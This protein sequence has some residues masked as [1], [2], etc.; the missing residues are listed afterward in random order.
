MKLVLSVIL[1]FMVSMPACLFGQAG[2]KDPA[3]Y[4]PGSVPVICCAGTTCRNSNYTYSTQ[5]YSPPYDWVISG[6]AGVDYTKTSGGGPT[7]HSISITW[8]TLGPQSVSVSYN[9]ATGYGTLP[10]TVEETFP[11]SVI[12]TPSANPV[13]A[14]TP[15]TFTITTTN[16]GTSPTYKWFRN[17][18]EVPG[19][20]NSTYTFI[21]ANNDNVYCEVTSSLQCPTGSPAS[22]PPV[23]IIV[24]SNFPVSVAV[25][26]S[27]NPVCQGS[28]VTFTAL[29][30][31]GGNTPSYQW[32]LGV[33][34]ISGATDSTYV[35]TPADGDLISC[36][37]TSS[38][39]CTSGNP[40]TSSQL[41]MTVS[42]VQ[43]VSVTVLPSANPVCA[44]NLV[45]YTATPV[46]GGTLP[47][48]TWTV[49]GTTIGLNGPTMQYMPVNGDAV[50]CTLNSNAQCQ[51]GN[52]ASSAAIM[53]NVQQFAPVSVSIVAS[54]STTLCNGAAVTLTATAINQGPGPVY[55]WYINN[56]HVSAASGSTY[57]YTPTNGDIVK[58]IVTS[59]L[60]CGT[61]NP[62]TSNEIF[63]T[64]SSVTTPSVTVAVSSNPVCAGVPVT[65]TATPAN[66]G[67]SPSYQWIKNGAN[68]FGA[69]TSVYIYTPANNDIVKCMMVSNSMCTSGATVFS[70]PVTM[71]VISVMAVSVTIQ[72]SENPVCQGGPVTFT[73]YPQPV[74]GTYSY[75]WMV[76]GAPSGGATNNTF[77][78][79]PV[80]GQVVT[81]VVTSPL[82]CVT[83]NPATSNAITMNVANSIPVSA[84]ITAS[85]NPSCLGSSVIF[86]V[87]PTNGGATPAFTWLVDGFPM[88]GA[89]NSTYSFVPSNGNT[90]ACTVISSYGCASGNPASSN[91]ITMAVNPTTPV[92]VV[93]TN[94]NDSSCLGVPM[95]YSAAVTGGGASP[96]Y[97]WTVN[98]TNSGINS[99]NF[100][101]IPAQGDIVKC[102]VTPD[103]AC[104]QSNPAV[105]N[106]ITQTVLPIV[107][108]DIVI[109]ASSNPVC[110]GTQV[111]Y[112]ISFISN[113]GTNPGYQWKKNG[114]LVSVSPVLVYTPANNDKISCALTSSL[115]CVNGNPKTSNEITMLVSDSLNV[116]ATIF[117]T[118][119]NPNPF[120]QGLPISFNSTV[121]NGG[122]P[123]T[124]PGYQ[125]LVNG[126]PPV[127]AATNATY[128]YIPADGDFVTLQVTSGLSCGVPKPFTSNPISLVKNNGLPAS[129]IITA[130]ENP[131][132]SGSN[133]TFHATP[134][135][136]G[137]APFYR[138]YVNGVQKSAGLS[139]NFSWSITDGMVIT[140]TVQSNLPCASGSPATSNAIIMGTVA[141]PVP[142]I[143]IST[144]TNPF[145][146]GTNVTFNSVITN[147]GST[148]GYQWN[149]N[150]NPISG[151]TNATYVTAT[152]LANN[153]II[154]CTMTSAASCIVGV[155]ATSNAITM[156]STSPLPLEILVTAS[157]NPVC[158][159]TTV[160]YTA[161]PANAG[162]SP[163]FQWQKNAF[164]IT[165][166]T[167]STY[168]HVPVNSDVIACKVTTSMVCAT[169]IDKTS[170]PLTMTVNT[171]LAVSFSI[172]ASANPVCLGTPVTLTASNIVNAGS[173]PVFKWRVD[174]VIL[175]TSGSTTFTYTPQNGDVV[176]A[177]MSSSLDCVSSNPAVSNVVVLQVNSPLPVSL[178]VAASDNPFCAG[179]GVTFVA[180]ASNGGTAPTYQWY[181]NT[182]LQPGE[183][184]PVYS[185]FPL[186][187]DEVYCTVNSNQSCISNNPAQS[188]T[189]HM[190]ATAAGMPATI[191]VTVNK[192]NVCPG[193]QL[194][195]SASITN[196]GS[197][198]VYQWYKNNN[199]VGTNVSTYATTCNNNDQVYCKITSNLACANPVV[200]NSNVIIM[201]VL[202]AAPVSIVITASSN[203][204][205]EGTAVTYTAAAV[206]PGTDP[207][208]RWKVN[209]IIILSSGSTS[210]TYTPIN[211]QVI[212]CQIQ[213]N[214]LCANPNVVNSNNII[215]SV[216][217]KAVVGVSILPSA[218]PICEGTSITY[219]ATPVNGGTL[220]AYQWKLNGAAAGTNSPTFSFTPV[221]NDKVICVITSNSDCVV[222]NTVSSVEDTMWVSPLLPV[223]ASIAASSNPVCQGYVTLSATATNGGILPL[224]QWKVN[225]IPGSLTPNNTLIYLPADGDQVTCDVTSNQFCVVGNP[226]T[227]NTVTL[228]VIPS[229]PVS[230]SIAPAVTPLPLCQGSSITFTATA[231][232]GGANPD[233]QWMLGNYTVGSGPSYTYIPASGDVITCQ[234]YSNITCPTGNP[235]TSAPIT[236]NFSPVLEPSVSITTSANPTCTG[237]M[238]SFTALPVN[239]GATPEFQWLVN[240]IPPVPAAT[241]A[242]YSYL[243]ANADV[244]T[245]VLTSGVTCP[246]INP[247][248]SNSITMS[249][250]QPQTAS[251]SISTPATS[252][253]DGI[254]VTFTA[255]LGNPGSTPVLQWFVNGTPTGATSTTYT[256]NPVNGDIVTCTLV[257][258]ISCITNNPV[259][260]NALQMTVSN[261]F[262]VSITIAPTANP[263]CV[264]QL[265][266]FTANPVN[267]GVNPVF[268]WM[269][270]G[271]NVGNNSPTYTFMPASGQVVCCQLKSDYIC[272]PD[273]AMSNC[274]TMVVKTIQ[275]VD[276]TL[277]CS[278]NPTCLGS[279]VTYTATPSNGGPNP[280]YTW[281]VNGIV[282]AGE[283][284]STYTYP[285]SSGDIVKCKL[286]SDES[287][288]NANPAMSEEITM[289]VS[290]SFP[291]DV[292]VTSTGNVVCVFTPVTFTAT[293]FFGGP[294]P[295]YQWQVNGTDVIGATNTTYLYYPPVDGNII[296]CVMTS[297]LSL[298]TANPVTSVP[299]VMIV[300]Q[301]PVSVVIAV[302][303]QTPVCEG[304]LVTFTATPTNGGPA[305]SYQWKV[306]ATNYP[307]ATN[308]TFTY[309]PGIS[310]SVNCL[311]MSNATCS[312]GSL[313][314]SNIII[315]PVNP[316][317]PVSVSVTSDHGTE[318]CAGTTITYSATHI[319][320]GTSPTYQWTVNSTNS[321]GATNS[322]FIYQPNNGE[323]IA[324]TLGSNATCATGSPAVSNTFTMTVHPLLPVSVSV[325]SSANNVCA[326]TT[327][328][329][330][331]TPGNGGTT[332]GYQWQV[333]GFN[334]SGETNSSYSYPP[335]NNDVVTCNMTADVV[336]PAS[337]PAVSNPITMVVSPMLP[338]SVSA[339]ASSNPVCAGASVLYTAT[340]TNGG[341]SGTYQ[342]KV[343]GGNIPGATNATWNYIPS[344]TEAI[345]CELNSSEVCPTGNPAISVPIAMTV[346]P[347][348]PLSV[349]VTG[350]NP[351]C[352][353]T[354][355]I[356]TAT[357]TN[358]GPSATYQWQLN[359][360]NVA[361]AT[362]STWTYTP[363]NGEAITCK[364]TSGETC[365]S[366]NPAISN[367]LKMV[368]NPLMPVSVTASASADPVCAGM[369][370]TYSASPVNGGVNP[371]YQWYVDGALQSGAT[372][373]TYSYS[374]VSGAAIT[375][376]VTSNAL[377][378]SGN[379]AISNPVIV[380]VNPTFPVS[381]SVFA[382][383]NPVCSGTPVTYTA[384]PV[385]GGV[386]PGYQWFVNG[387]IITGATNSILV[388]TPVNNDSFTCELTSTLTCPAGNPAVSQPFISTIGSPVV[389]YSACHDVETTINAKPFKLRGG[390]PLG[391]AYSGPG[392]NSGT[393][394]FD[395][396]AAGPGVIAIAYTYTASTG[397][398]VNSSPVIITNHNPAPLNCASATASVTDVRDNK[399]YPVVQIGSQCW[400]AQNLDYGSLKTATDPQTD[401]CINDKYC[402]NNLEANCTLYGGLYQWDELM[403]H[404][405]VAG[406][407]GLCP[408]GWH[409]P[410]DA[411]WLVLFNFYSGQ[412]EAGT[413][414][415]DQGPGS[416]RATPGGLLYQNLPNWSFTPPGFSGSFYWT[417]D[418]SGQWKAVSHGL[419]SAVGSVSDYVSGR[420]NAFSA[421]CLL[422]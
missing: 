171:P 82:T 51:T 354:S 350:S 217:P 99:A 191:S 390:L 260:S 300:L 382:S 367:P 360:F 113:Q 245:C 276:V 202:P 1:F 199:P 72:A 292:V 38:L 85:A 229:A 338:V 280:E 419:N 58:C 277:T 76:N 326:G 290:T 383:A 268:Q 41:P 321:P 254:P 282:V 201:N 301:I 180:T 415:K 371:A 264:G 267:G 248:N 355:V 422:D 63:L 164:P 84:T 334:I 413:A 163:Q 283:T 17:M 207:L 119:T 336:C 250:L 289:I 56:T 320:G 351:V 88:S 127:P 118:G 146:P 143:S 410:T 406:S 46:N 69:T 366:G 318:V 255:N 407:Q 331:A 233:F 348:L 153:D 95:A 15:V 14:G 275:P 249:V 197:A 401:N 71:M 421:R 23:T 337:N 394:V 173:S 402:V 305:P 129:V 368:V 12:I 132:C 60:I 96:V 150:G 34:P 168:T 159:G 226:A 294:S 404:D 409:V 18:M 231:V 59:S 269:V 130:S 353:G 157:A 182:I 83:G 357:P 271:M 224:Y 364:L 134:T 190:I 81:C 214:Q 344:N 356:Y 128:S 211:G 196:G 210:F 133:V 258:S 138:W 30:F 398:V 9:G 388:Y 376:E 107:S 48:Y 362:N 145:C 209:G 125:W 375:C 144:L 208:Y 172:A 281:Y 5:L 192:N 374:P 227:S 309:A 293:P 37:V 174:G 26:A 147:G 325:V 186:D 11:V 212:S 308:P 7:D 352:S 52:P 330:T 412:S 93:I 151:A 98:S 181:K 418:P 43:P 327:V 3:Q 42:P 297:S 67:S 284:N 112:S 115:M 90:F 149:L 296:T 403:K 242:T 365:I 341:A 332:P 400:L 24:I 274:V 2:M 346:N 106:G 28:P 31:N 391:G 137:T 256:Y 378:P 223:S 161:A 8:H 369:V 299:I 65:Y 302:S 193:T 92:S 379:P 411:E 291:A 6:T 111:T 45:T 91:I 97:Q 241:N 221:N 372:N 218:N 324:C 203:P 148:P 66:G 316:N 21:P 386:S 184:N 141:A 257:S 29:P 270:N 77:T 359:G 120:C 392:V 32:L 225:G 205:C 109:G 380:T 39:G 70:T 343:N 358:G 384:I 136:G 272:E 287:C 235:A 19:E 377:C 340:P 216:T 361:F 27:S 35:Y 158:Q 396:L 198:P 175:Q 178:T 363:I 414:L 397:C 152:A 389:T 213:S 123:P 183:T 342:W 139:A 333:N 219:T 408:P 179:N 135:N 195:F 416:F 16:A 166:A 20:T 165:G 230:V 73:A 220:P 75:Q 222:A 347:L 312:S 232:N 240:G 142:A 108:P 131:V 100:S 328:T 167:N 237:T 103:V 420:E 204:C 62:A 64:V 265:V 187:N 188:N 273:P 323:I 373:E 304:T 395:P 40:A 251:I 185:Y 315:P 311:L 322:T 22:S 259:T 339:T 238:V 154:T 370:V 87:V 387:T 104:P 160:Q 239:G 381:V 10:V 278:S 13:C 140:C 117:I 170:E 101:Y 345:S 266:T 303:P 55:Q 329:F 306:D 243:P 405:P 105:S 61:G 279:P 78:Y 261:E 236:M 47:F 252:V 169:P 319:N 200:A 57:V 89:T 177:T 50:V 124:P 285:P 234:L 25:T 262:P 114:V 4:A 263:S 122:T 102:K 399:V 215:A 44:T 36:T 194:L 393:G 310:N 286:T 295:T 121:T 94:A 162:S 176:T 86:T 313:A 317:L 53:M 116:V 385:N 244:V 206:N 49:N 298:C 68:V 253:C 189:V 349:S 228:T 33:N 156:I 54:P 74:I 417:S 307:G 246:L 126:V 80:N 110:T 155:Q 79:I 288:V 335:Q 247:V 314:A